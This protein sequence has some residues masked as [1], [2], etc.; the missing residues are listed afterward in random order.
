MAMHVVIRVNS[1]CRIYKSTLSASSETFLLFYNAF[2]H[3]CPFACT[4]KKFIEH[5]RRT[6][7]P[8]RSKL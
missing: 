4:N 8:G 6:H 7:L 1:V 5:W 2:A 3:R